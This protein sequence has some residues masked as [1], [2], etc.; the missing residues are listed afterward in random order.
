MEQN[1]D[2]PIWGEVKTFQQKLKW[3]ETKDYNT[4]KTIFLQSYIF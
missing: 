2:K 4:L 1:T 3:T